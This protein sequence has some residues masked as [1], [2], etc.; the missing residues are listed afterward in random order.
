MKVLLVLSLIGLVSCGPTP[1]QFNFE[2]L[3]AIFKSIGDG[4]LSSYDEGLE[5]VKY[6]TINKTLDGDLAFEIRQYAE[7]KWVCT[8]MTYDMPE[9]EAEVKEETDN[10]EYGFLAN[11]AEKFSG[12]SWKKRP[13][14]VEF[15]RLFRYISGV[16][17]ERQEI[18]MTSPVL[19]KMS[20]NQDTNM[21]TNRMCFYLDS[22][23]RQNPPKPDEQG[24]YLLTSKPLTVAVYE[25][26]GYAMQDTVWMKR[27]YEFKNKLG[28]R[29]N[30]LDTTNFYT[31]GYDSPMKFLKRKNEVMFE[32]KN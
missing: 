22:A 27:A 11:L 3:K 31:A 1:Q 7:V 20:P 23:A 9:V 18:E 12:Q 26:G 15:M 8:N 2:S 24:V 29:A 6:K 4:W 16:N 10:E 19:S 13:S 21:M 17:K 30:S 32:L 5:K 14:S 25:F 28:D